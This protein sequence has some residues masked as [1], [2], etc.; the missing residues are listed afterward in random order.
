MQYPVPQFVDVENKIIGPI[1]VRQFTIASIGLA[2]VFLL[3]KYADT[4][5]FI[6][7]TIVIVLFVVIVGFVR[8]NGRPFHYFFLSILETLFKS[9]RLYVWKKEPAKISHSHKGKKKT[10]KN[11]EMP[12]VQ[13]AREKMQS[14]S[15]IDDLSFLVDT[16]GYGK[17][18]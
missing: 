9:G 18:K 6:F 5:L 12:I 4:G 10:T 1:T 2:G 17:R 13:I 3:F 15:R 11:V 16:A 7:A 14:Y 8:I